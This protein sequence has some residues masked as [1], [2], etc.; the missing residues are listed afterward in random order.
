MS[1]PRFAIAQDAP[2]PTEEQLAA[3]RVIRTA[4]A[5]AAHAIES[6]TAPGRERALALTKLEEALMWAGKAIF[7]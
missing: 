7:A 5:T 4:I 6:G 1:D 2:K 3:Q